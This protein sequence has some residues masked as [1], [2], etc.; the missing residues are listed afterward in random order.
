MNTLE[1][2]DK[3]ELL[4]SQAQQIIENAEK[5]SR[6]LNAGEQAEFDTITK[7]IAQIEA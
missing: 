6:K 1:M 4:K 5:E 7:E 2:T 3:K